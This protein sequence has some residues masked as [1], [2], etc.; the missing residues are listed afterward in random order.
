VTRAIRG[1]TAKIAEVLPE[2]ATVLDR[3]VRTGLYCAFEP[4]EGDAVHWSFI[5]D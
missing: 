4:I 2:A 1:A 5:A 3:R